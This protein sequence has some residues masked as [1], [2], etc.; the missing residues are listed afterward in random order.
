MPWRSMKVVTDIFVWVQ[1]MFSAISSPVVS[2]N[3]IKTSAAF[4]IVSKVISS[5]MELFITV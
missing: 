5:F 1:I 2:G 4:G 3:N